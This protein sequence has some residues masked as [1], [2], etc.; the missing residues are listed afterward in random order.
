MKNDGHHFKR[1]GG[2]LASATIQ[3]HARTLK[4]FSSWLHREGY[5][6]ENILERLRSPKL[7]ESEIVPVTKPEVDPAAR[8]GDHIETVHGEHR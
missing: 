8:E 3:G 6:D 5:S 7:R 4:S 2:R 1:A